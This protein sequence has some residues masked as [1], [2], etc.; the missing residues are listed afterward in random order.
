M[1]KDVVAV[2][3]LSD[4]RL[5][6]TFDDRVEGIINVRE[7]VQFTGVFQ[8]LQDATFF[9]QV[10]VNPELGTVC[11]PNDADLDSEVLYAKVTGRAIPEYM[12]AKK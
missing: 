7:L 2:Q 12:T 3:P 4:H 1:L 8:P 10:K 9:A 11:W 6:V 5:R